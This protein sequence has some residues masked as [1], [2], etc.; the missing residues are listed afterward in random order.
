MNSL[1][2][3]MAVAAPMASAIQTASVGGAKIVNHCSSDFSLT[4][5]PAY[6]PSSPKQ[7][8]ATLAANNVGEDS[9]YFTPWISLDVAGGWSMKLPNPDD[10]ANIAQ[11]EYTWTGDD[12][13][14]TDMSFVF[15]DAQ[16]FPDW[17]FTCSDGATFT[18]DYYRNSTDDANGMQVPVPLSATV[19]LALCPSGTAAATTAA[20]TTAPVTTEAT[21]TAAPTTAAAPTTTPTPTTT[22]STTTKAQAPTTTPSTTLS[23]AYT[24]GNHVNASPATLAM[25]EGTDGDVEIVTEY[26]TQ[27]VTAVVT[28]TAHAKR[29][30]HE[31]R[32]PHGPH[33]N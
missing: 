20:A 9:T 15:N 10:T 2:A 22:P 7:V 25:V 27:V 6:A 13:V 5:V 18:K 11:F 16:N 19:T 12:Q 24:P 30:R 3:L 14:W 8:S 21:T 32:H 28:E 26:A 1:I 23:K 33:G 4:N 29:R 31:H 17:E